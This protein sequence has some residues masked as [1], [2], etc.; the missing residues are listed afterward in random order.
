MRKLVILLFLFIGC[1]SS[2]EETG[3]VYQG[4]W[5][6]GWPE[7]G[8]D[9]TPYESARFIVYSDKSTQATRVQVA[10][11]AENAL[12]DLLD[13]FQIDFDADLDF[14]PNYTSRKIHILS[15][16]EQQTNGGLA[17]RDGL[18]NR[19][20]DSPRYKQFGTTR[21][22]WLRTLQHEISHVLEFMLIG[23]PKYQQANNVWL[24]EGAASYGA[25]IH[26]VQTIEQLDQWEK[27]ME[28]IPGGGN[29]IKIHRWSDF[30]TSVRNSSSE[31]NYYKFFELSSRYLVDPEGNGTTKEDLKLLY[32][33]LGEGIP[34][35]NA[36]QNR[37]GMSV[38][39]F[40][41]QWWEKMQDYLLK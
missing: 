28:N 14:L 8:H 3:L 6:V 29:P 2:E 36:F 25:R 31:I 22:V 10:N 35:N 30:P 16:Y 9:G 40:E 17:Y 32:E 4:S 1:N 24:R 26:T 27:E 20:P 5:R 12:D 23:D 38:I 34:F 13:I 7:L 33:D 18:I 11:D 15:D 41:N 39:E 37:F 21:E 19:A